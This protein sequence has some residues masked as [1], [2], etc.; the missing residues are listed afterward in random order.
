[1]ANVTLINQS[2]TSTDYVWY[3]TEY[4]IYDAIVTITNL[5]TDAFG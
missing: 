4:A 3:G 2:T 1:M 5:T